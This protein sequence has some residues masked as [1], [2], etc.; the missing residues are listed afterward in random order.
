M[1][2]TPKYGLIKICFI[3]YIVTYTQYR[4]IAVIILKSIVSFSQKY[5]FFRLPKPLQVI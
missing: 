2:I 5:T 1:A 3:F 4:V